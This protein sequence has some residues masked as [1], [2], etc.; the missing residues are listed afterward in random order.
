[1]TARNISNLSSKGTVKTMPPF[2]ECTHREFTII[3]IG[4]M[5]L[6]FNAGLLN[7]TTTQGGRSVSTAPM[8]G[9]STMIGVGFAEGNFNTVALGGGIILCNIFGASIAGT[10]TTVLFI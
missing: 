8:T 9:D 5:L 3:T 10:G 7:S 2:Q 6:A 4:G 1:M